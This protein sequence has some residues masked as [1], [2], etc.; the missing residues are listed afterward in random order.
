MK[1][2]NYS[3]FTLDLKRRLLDLQFTQ[4]TVSKQHKPALSIQAIEQAVTA[5]KLMIDTLESSSSHAEQ[6]LEDYTPQCIDTLYPVPHFE[7][8]L[9]SLAQLCQE[10]AEEPKKKPSLVQKTAKIIPFVFSI[11]ESQHQQSE[12]GPSFANTI[13]HDMY[14][15]AIDCIQDMIG[16]LAKS[17]VVLS[18][19]EE[20][21]AFVEPIASAVVFGRTFMLN[22]E[23]PQPRE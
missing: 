22:M 17:S 1:K 6:I 13:K 12:K 15:E 18:V 11:I 8:K 4:E 21:E 2:G 9:R 3:N 14:S 23:N 19:D 10:P 5:T 20:D 7:K 16:Y